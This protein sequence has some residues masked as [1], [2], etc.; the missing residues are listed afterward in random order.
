M[1]IIL[2]LFA[3]LISEQAWGTTYRYSYLP[4][5]SSPT[6][7]NFLYE[8]REKCSIGEKKE[9]PHQIGVCASCPDGTVY[10]VDEDLKKPF[11]Y[12]C[13][14]GTLLVR[15]SDY[16]MC[17][18][19]YPVIR[20][21]ALKPNE[22]P[23]SEE[24][25]ERTARRLGADYKAALPVKA[26]EEQKTFRNKEKLVNVCPSLYPEDELA[27]KQIN[28]CR[29]LARQNDFLCPYVEKNPDGKWICRACP[30]NAPYKNSQGGCFTC[31]YGEE[32][33]DLEDGTLVCASQAPANKK[34]T[35]VIKSKSEKRKK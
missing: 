1:K 19:N 34:K 32:M 29:R 3:L 5:T 25:L 6:I 26:K 33:V 30:K 20:G 4:K 21:K 9:Y 12:K 7:Y 15:R 18:T 27:Q 17:L 24:D 16:P 23:V 35:S 13:P 8:R 2:F 28:I 11:C 31:P 10:L 14:S 22:T